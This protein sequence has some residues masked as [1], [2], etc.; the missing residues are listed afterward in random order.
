MEF[1]L[2]GL[3]PPTAYPSTAAAFNHGAPGPR[4]GASPSLFWKRTQCWE[5]FAVPARKHSTLYTS[6]GAWIVMSSVLALLELLRFF[7]GRWAR[8]C[9][10]AVG[11][12]N[13]E[14]RLSFRLCCLNVLLF[15]FLER[16][17]HRE[18]AKHPQRPGWTLVRRWD[19]VIFDSYMLIHISTLIGLK[20]TTRREITLCVK[21]HLYKKYFCC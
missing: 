17:R 14:A 2:W 1:L 12:L 13:S 7:H 21:N 6:H 9:V 18:H 20:S 16:W 8:I 10:Y 11:N 19:G 4:W 3:Q 5:I 15:L